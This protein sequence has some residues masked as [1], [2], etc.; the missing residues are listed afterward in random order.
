MVCAPYNDPRIE[1]FFGKNKKPKTA[2]KYG[3]V[4]L[5][6]K[7]REL[8]QFKKIMTKKLKKVS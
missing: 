2:W 1:W 5:D 7:R 4:I 8:E 3:I 6:K